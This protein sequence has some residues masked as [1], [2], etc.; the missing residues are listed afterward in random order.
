MIFASSVL[1]L[2]SWDFAVHQSDVVHMAG[3][4]GKKILGSKALV[5]LATW[6]DFP[7]FLV[8]D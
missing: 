7:Q 5:S 1:I 4:Q 2:G 6:Q 8:A 3:P